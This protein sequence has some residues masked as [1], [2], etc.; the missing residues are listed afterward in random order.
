MYL[1][2]LFAFVQLDATV[3]CIKISDAYS[4]LIHDIKQAQSTIF[5]PMTIY[6]ILRSYL[7]A[8]N[9]NPRTDYIGHKLYIPHSELLTLPPYNY[10]LTHQLYCLFLH[11][12]VPSIFV[13]VIP[14]KNNILIIFTKI[15]IEQ[16]PEQVVNI[17]LPIYQD[18]LHGPNLTKMPESAS[19]TLE[20]S[21]LQN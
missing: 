2:Q 3:A 10:N 5:S 16:I 4:F 17:L 13:N 9:N 19:S 7:Y 12:A 20:L 6:K 1:K 15:P 21:T 14:Q 11:I 18:H 8:N